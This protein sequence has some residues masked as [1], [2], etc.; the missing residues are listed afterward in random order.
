MTADLRV[1]VP[2]AAV[3]QGSMRLVQG[4]RRMI[5]SNPSLAAW[6]A[7]VAAHVI[8]AIVRTERQVGTCFPLTGPVNLVCV[9]TFERPK[10]HYRSGRYAAMLKDRAPVYMQTGPDL[11]KLVRAIGDALV[12][13]CA[14]VDDKQL[15]VIHA[16][17]KWCGESDSPSATIDLWS[18]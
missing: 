3:P 13:A 15:N 10:S 1:T 6:R 14:I 8:A 5:H 16:G 2:G 17:K 4:G 9:F 7:T 12:S 11:D 18:V